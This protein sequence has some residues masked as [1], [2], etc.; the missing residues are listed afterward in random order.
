MC[1]C[2]NGKEGSQEQ[3][4]QSTEYSSN[5]D[6]VAY[7]N[8]SRNTSP[9]PLVVGLMNH[10]PIIY[11]SSAH[12]CPSAVVSLCLRILSIAYTGLFQPP[13]STISLVSSRSATLSVFHLRLSQM[14]ILMHSEGR[15][16]AVPVPK[17]RRG[18]AGLQ[19]W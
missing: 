18:N 15:G 9:P 19:P 14:P 16:T 5:Y 8:R 3:R 13:A 1:R 10:W 6:I 11:P 4:G 17:K 2:R 12:I 7:A